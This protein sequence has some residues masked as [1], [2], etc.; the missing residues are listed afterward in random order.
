MRV[1]IITPSI[2]KKGLQIV[3]KSLLKQEYK[4]FEWLIG[5]K[6]DPEIP[7]AHWV[8]DDFEGGFWTLNRMYNKLIK[9]SKG[10]IIISWQDNV[11]APP[12]AIQKFESTVSAVRSPV[13][14]VGDQYSVLSK[15]GK[16]EIKIWTDPRRTTQY[17]SFYQINHN[18]IE[19]NFCACD[20]QLLYAVGGAD[21]KLDFL[22]RGGDMFQV[23]DRL[24]DLNVPFWI[25]QT[26]ESL[27][28]QHGREDY[29]GEDEWN[30]SHVLFN[31]KYNERKKELIETQQW[32]ILNYL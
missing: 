29:G 4:D 32:P 13:T 30:K 23:T 8:K 20:K 10:D 31:G 18:D 17:G 12:D 27:T 26:N 11:W 9:A 14:G 3:L 7:E 19:W 16:P 2:R 6:F 25:D 24:N 22:G 5:S 1:S 28:L 15:W 21:E